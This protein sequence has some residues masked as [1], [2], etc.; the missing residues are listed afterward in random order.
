MI[1]FVDDERRRMQSYV[2][3][4][5]L[6]GYEVEFKSDVDD[7]LIFFEENKEKLD[8]LIL[9]VMMPTGNS[10]NNQYADDGLRTGICFHEKVRHQNQSIPIII[11]TN[12]PVNESFDTESGKT[13]VFQKDMLLPFDLTNKVNHILKKER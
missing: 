4:L 9:D 10:F 2:E 6:S 1:L 8:L 11:F 13:F 12:T 7:A 3:E 5:K